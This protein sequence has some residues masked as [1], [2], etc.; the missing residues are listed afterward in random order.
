M[1]KHQCAHLPTQ[2]HSTW[3]PWWE[4]WQGCPLGSAR[5]LRLSPVYGCFFLPMGGVGSSSM[6]TSENITVSDLSFLWEQTAKP[7]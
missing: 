2:G 1:Y 6:V 3:I 4:R 7:T 5:N